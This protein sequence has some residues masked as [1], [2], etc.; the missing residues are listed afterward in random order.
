MQIATANIIITLPALN[1]AERLLGGTASEKSNGNATAAAPAIITQVIS[2]T[3]M[4]L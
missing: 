2:M 4:R 3:L 1:F